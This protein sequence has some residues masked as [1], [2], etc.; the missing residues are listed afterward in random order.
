MLVV[1]E[2]MV[3][4]ATKN[5]SLQGI[6]LLLSF[7]RSMAQPGQPSTY[8]DVAGGVGGASSPIQIGRYVFDHTS[9]LNCED[10]RVV[11]TER[12]Y[13]RSIRVHA[14]DCNDVLCQVRWRHDRSHCCQSAMHV[15]KKKTMHIMFQDQLGLYVS[16]PCMPPCRRAQVNEQHATSL[17]RSTGR[18]V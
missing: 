18:P 15:V 16:V 3:V 9:Q 1:P 6:A 14:D 5:N 12:L 11:A 4:M 17:P 13:R 10:M 2:A 8:S 7:L